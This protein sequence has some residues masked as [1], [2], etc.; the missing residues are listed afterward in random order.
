MSTQPRPQMSQPLLII[1]R[2]RRASHRLWSW[3]SSLVITLAWLGS[4]VIIWAPLC[5]YPTAQDI[6]IVAG[7]STALVVAG[8]STVFPTRTPAWRTIAWA[9]AASVTAG[10]TTLAL[11]LPG[12]LAYAPW[13][14]LAAV[15]AALLVTAGR[16]HSTARVAFRLL[17]EL[18]WLR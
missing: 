7:S 12:M 8:A 17:R 13:P 15:A 5:A 1:A 18:R 14:T 9:W 4:L 3:M 16:T 6:G 10:F 11:T 2:A